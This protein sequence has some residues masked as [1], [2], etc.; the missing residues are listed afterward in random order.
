MDQP[1][2]LRQLEFAVRESQR[3]V[4]TADCSRSVGAVASAGALRPA[5]FA[6]TI[7]G[8]N[9]PVA[10]GARS[11]WPFSR[12]RIGRCDKNIQPA[13]ILSASSFALRAGDAQHIKPADQ[14]KL[15]A[16]PRSIERGL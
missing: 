8:V 15:S 10:L 9:Q 11:I 3:R 6:S 7:I 5:G 12:P 14:A 1:R 16:S 4:I 13:D 2:R